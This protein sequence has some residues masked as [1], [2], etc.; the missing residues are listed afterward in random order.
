MAAGATLGWPV[1]ALAIEDLGGSGR[2]LRRPGSYA[3]KVVAS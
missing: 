1:L 3:V 2:G